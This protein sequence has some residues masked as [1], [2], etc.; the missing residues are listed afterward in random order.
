M[1]QVKTTK[2]IKNLFKISIVFSSQNSEHLPKHLNFKNLVRFSFDSFARHKNSEKERERLSLTSVNVEANC[3]IAARYRK[4]K[5]SELN[6]IE[7]KAFSF[8]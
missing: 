1:V 8:H 5:R 2:F 3:K 6:Q 4:Q 7:Q